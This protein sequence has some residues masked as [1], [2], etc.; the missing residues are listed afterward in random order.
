MPAPPFVVL[1]AQG[2][3]VRFVFAVLCG[4]HHAVDSFNLK[5]LLS[6]FFGGVPQIGLPGGH[7]LL[8]YVIVLGLVDRLQR[9]AL[10]LLLFKT[11]LTQIKSWVR[12]NGFAVDAF[13]GR[14]SSLLRMIPAAEVVSSP[15]RGIHIYSS[16]A[17]LQGTG[18]Y[19][20]SCQG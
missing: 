11:G 16:V 19:C 5:G 15:I 14:R 9:G 7:E 13:C 8:N 1:W 10:T 2:K 20:W 3:L 6:V 17:S 4:I 12:G 18:F